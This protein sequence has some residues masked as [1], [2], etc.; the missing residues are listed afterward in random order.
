M[1]RHSSRSQWPF[2]RSVIGWTLPWLVL[3]SV[4][5]VGIWFGVDALSNDEIESPA[6][7]AASQ[8]PREE[9]KEPASPSPSKE[10]E[11]S[12]SP[13]PEASPS[14]DVELITENMTVQIL[15]GTSDPG[16]DDAMA[17]ELSE[18][19]FDVVSVQ[20]ASISYEA[21]TVFWSYAESQE[22]AEALAAR[23]GWAVASKPDN[24]STTVALHV[25][26]GA[27]RVP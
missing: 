18:L 15:N 23:F 17:N 13:S 16:A 14:T 5:A 11:P 21:T 19:G 7:A 2:Y 12:A 8:S 9:P 24:L 3:A 22:A 20:E 4:V 26:V 1:G 25:V 27:D 6:P 10:A